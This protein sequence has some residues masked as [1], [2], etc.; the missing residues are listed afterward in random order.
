MS[1]PVL[2][3]DSVAG[4]VTS[5]A[6]A[7]ELLGTVQSV[8]VP[9]PSRKCFLQWLGITLVA[10]V[11]ATYAIMAGL[12]AQVW[13]TDESHMTS[14]IT[15]ITLLVGA[16]AGIGSWN[17]GENFAK[18]ESLISFFAEKV[19]Y[20]GLFGTTWGLIGQTRAIIG[21]NLSDPAAITS[22]I[23]K[24]MGSIGTS[25]ETTGA[26]VLSAVILGLMAFNIR[27]EVE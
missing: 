2:A 19:M 6:S 26:G 25:L 5:M 4:E 14:V 18:K 11:A 12:P 27:H 17:P 10:G 22:L 9:P 15:A 16:Y 23:G 24:L 7:Y 13:A 1:K 3:Y 8:P 20:V 21:M